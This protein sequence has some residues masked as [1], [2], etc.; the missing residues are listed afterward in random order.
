MKI[1]LF[2]A[3]IAMALAGTFTSTLTETD[4][5]YDFAFTTVDYTDGG[6]CSLVFGIS[7]KTQYGLSWTTP[8]TGGGA[9][10]AVIYKLFT[11]GTDTVPATLTTANLATDA[12]GTPSGAATIAYSATDVLEASLAIDVDEI[13]YFAAE[14]ITTDLTTIAGQWASDEANTP[15]AAITSW[16]LTAPT[17]DFTWGAAESDNAVAMTAGS[18]AIAATFF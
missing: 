17:G 10:T 15:A 11:E 2:T 5:G 7:G 3:V 13:L 8:A 4:D 16:T 14:L 1:I 9:A 18:L 12:T 6:L